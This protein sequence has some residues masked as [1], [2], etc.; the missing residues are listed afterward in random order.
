VAVLGAEYHMDDDLTKGSRHDRR[1]NGCVTGIGR[2]TKIGHW[3]GVDASGLQPST[4]ARL[5]KPMA[6]PWAGMWQ[7]FGLASNE[8]V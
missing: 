7:A 6:E 2:T 1:S 4:S 3:Y 5:L 8:D